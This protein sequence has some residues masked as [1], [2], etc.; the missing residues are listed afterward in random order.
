MP[1]HWVIRW[2]TTQWRKKAKVRD[3]QSFAF[4]CVLRL[5]RKWET[6]LLKRG[7]FNSPQMIIMMQGQLRTETAVEISVFLL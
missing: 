7:R 1:I 6:Q 3:T 4:D 5:Q 2:R